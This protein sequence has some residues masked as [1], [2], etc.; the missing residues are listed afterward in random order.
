[1]DNRTVELACR[2]LYEFFKA[3]RFS[4][5]NGDAVTAFLRHMEEA[6]A[7]CVPETVVPTTRPAVEGEQRQDCAAASDPRLEH[8]RQQ[9]TAAR[10][11]EQE[12]RQAAD[13]LSTKLTAA[14]NDAE[15]AR[16]RAKAAEEQLDSLR[17][18]LPRE[19]ETLAAIQTFLDELPPE[20]RELI[21]TYFTTDSLVTF[22]VQCGQ[23]NRLNQL[24]AACG[25]A[26]MDGRTRGD[27]GESLKFLL[28]LFNRADG[29]NPA[30]M[31]SPAPGDAYRSEIHYR[32]NSDGVTVRK[33]LLPGLRN[34]GGKVQ[35]N[36]LVQLQ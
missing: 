6:N 22:L 4:G 5:K 35:Q 20:T 2:A 15:Q 13:D 7:P 30:T 9:L 26:V 32:V 25:K 17:T 29:Q 10:A 27:T 28:D 36:A 16:S 21:S 3:G 1:M 33:L 8:L 34:P 23:F 19:Q 24:W 11:A 18:R 12:A 14:N 31:V